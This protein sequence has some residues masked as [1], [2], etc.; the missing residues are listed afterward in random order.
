MVSAVVAREEAT[1]VWYCRE[2]QGEEMG[3][4]Q[5]RPGHTHVLHRVTGLAVLTPVQCVH[6]HLLQHLKVSVRR[7]WCAV[8]RHTEPVVKGL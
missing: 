6:A 5:C 8:G 7:D 4:V 3:W 1:I 2:R